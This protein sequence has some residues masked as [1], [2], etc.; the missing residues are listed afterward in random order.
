MLLLCAVDALARLEYRDSKHPDFRHSGGV[1]KRFREYLKNAIFPALIKCATMKFQLPGSDKYIEF[2]NILYKYFRCELVHKAA[3]LDILHP[4]DQVI[5]IDWGDHSNLM[6]GMREAKGK[7]VIGGNF[8]LELIVRVVES[9]ITG[10]PAK[11][12]VGYE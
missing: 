11:G 12:L 3:N 6:V 10:K 8:L 9:G 4:T 5:V 1:G 7:I 2:E